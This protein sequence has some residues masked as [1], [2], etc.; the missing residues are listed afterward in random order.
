MQ[1]SMMSSSSGQI[2]MAGVYLIWD[3]TANRPNYIGEGNRVV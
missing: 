1:R 2:G 3:S